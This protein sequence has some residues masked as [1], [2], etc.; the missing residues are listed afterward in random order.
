MNISEQLL[1]KALPSSED[2]EQIVIGSILLDNASGEEVFKALVPSDFYHPIYRRVFGSMIELSQMNMVIDPITIGENMKSHGQ[3]LTSIGGVGAITNITLGIPLFGSITEYVALIKKHSVARKTLQLLHGM[4]ED[5]LRGED[6]IEDVLE[7]GES[8]LLTLSSRVHSEGS[9]P[10]KG[11]WDLSDITPTLEARFRGYNA[12]II[13]GAPTGMPELDKMLDEG[14]LQPGGLYL[15]AAS[16]KTGKTSLALDWAYNGAV[17]QGLTVPIVTMEMSRENLAKRLYSAHTGIPYYMFRAGFYDS[18]T[19]KS[20]TRAL[21]GLAEFGKF[22]IKIADKLF[23]LPEIAR[24][25]RRVVE[26]GLKVG[27]PVKYG[28][29]DYMQLVEGTPGAKTREQEV[30]NVSRNLKK[31]AAELEIALVVLSSLNRANLSEGQEPGPINL[32]D[33]GA[34]AFDAEALIFLHNPLYVPGKPYEPQQVTDIAMILSRQRN[35]P[36]GRIPLKFIGPYMQ[37]MTESQYRK[38]FRDDGLPKSVGQMIGE[39]RELDKLW[40]ESERTTS[41][42]GEDIPWD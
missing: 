6:P 18:Q 39:S 42:Q 12:G 11:F 26:I 41:I 36:T 23:G 31:L 33:S 38:H 25:L 20:Y 17:I 40:D 19:D 22:P 28:I 7:R 9:I 27:H 24:H 29:I 34:L 10:D 32:R 2:A 35:G 37:F 16:E 14:G 5:I 8:T 21:E 15:I 4:T 13:T 30:S 1:D 3:E